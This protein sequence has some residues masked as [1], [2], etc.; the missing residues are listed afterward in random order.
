MLTGFAKG[1]QE[2]HQKASIVLED[3]VRN[4]YTIVAYCASTK[5]MELYKLQL[6]DILKRSLVHGMGIG[7]VFG[8]SQFLLFSCNAFLLWY[9]AVSVKDGRINLVTA[10]KEYMVLTFATF[11]LMEPFGLAPYILKRRK[12][13]ASVFQIIDREA[14]INP[15]DNEGLKPPN[16]YGS[17]EL[18]NVDFY[19]P[20]QPDVFVLR[21]FSL[22][23]GGGQTVALV[24]A[25]GSGKSTILSLI[26][27]FYDSVAGQA[28]LDGRDLKSYNLRWLRSHMGLVQQEPVIFSTSIRENIIYARH[29]ATEAEIKEAA[30]IANAHQFISSLPQGYDTH[31]GMRGVDLT[32]GQMQRIAIARVVLK[33]APILLLDEPSSA[34]ES[35]SNRMVQEALDT[36]IMGNKTTILVAHR[37]VSIRNVDNIVVL[38]DGN[39]V[40]QG[41][42]DALMQRNGLYV[43]LMQPHLNRGLRQHRHV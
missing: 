17:I 2:M 14:K 20:T 24:G 27:R 29:N 34:I 11:A 15:D 16:V 21:N 4:I 33:N 28:L 8:L 18:R 7:F 39:I 9:I 22:K 6:A 10:L 37:A 3:A 38:N 36:L 31:V 19:Y 42:H 26:E 5:V 30:R 41:T 23:V 32:P 25:S 12:S 43:Q 1:I 13:L 40:E 35:E